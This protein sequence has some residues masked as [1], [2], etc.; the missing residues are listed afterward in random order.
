[1][2]EIIQHTA[3]VRMRVAAASLEELF[4]DAVR[5]LM[6]VVKPVGDGDAV[7]LQLDVAAPDTTTLLVDFLNEVLTRTHIASEAYEEV[8]I[9]AITPERVVARLR[10]RAVDGF[11]EDVKA[12]TYHEADVRLSDGVWT[13]LLVFDI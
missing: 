6:E 9:A 7:T 13:T 11:E 10:G 4:G 12:V 8:A 5:G 1:M 3:D 2:Y